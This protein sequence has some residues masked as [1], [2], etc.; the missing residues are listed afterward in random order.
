MILII[1]KNIFIP[2]KRKKKKNKM[3]K[4]KELKKKYN[5]LNV[6]RLKICG[7]LS[8]YEIDKSIDNDDF[9]FIANT[10]INYFENKDIGYLL[11]KFKESKLEEKID[12][13]DF[14]IEEWNK[15]QDEIKEEID[16]IKKENPDIKN[17]N[18][19]DYIQEMIKKRKAE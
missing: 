8:D 17:L 5:N 9:N 10:L 2:K 12:D 13:V 19:D 6:N 1:L 11:T 7:Y 15:I 16:K 4:L 14:S 18:K 3:E